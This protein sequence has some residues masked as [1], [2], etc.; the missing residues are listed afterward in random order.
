MTKF[1]NSL[2]YRA[3]EEMEERKKIKDDLSIVED[4]FKLIKTTATQ[5]IFPKVPPRQI[6]DRSLRS[7]A[8]R[9]LPIQQDE[10]PKYI[11]ASKFGLPMSPMPFKAKQT[12]R[13]AERILNLSALRPQKNPTSTSSSST[14]TS[15]EQFEFPPIEIHQL[16]TET[17]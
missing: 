7:R 5:M 8:T 6:Q 13:N 15:V 11:P 4:D 3:T 10:E 9:S 14:V 1:L 12:S 16:D 2:R 17:P